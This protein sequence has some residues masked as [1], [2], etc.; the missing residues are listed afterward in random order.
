[1]KRFLIGIL[2]LS[3]FSCNDDLLDIPPKDRISDVA[4]WSDEALIKAY[5]NALYNSILH[6]FNIHMQSKATDEAYCAINWDIG[7]IPLGNLRPDNV[8]SVADTHWTGGGSLYNWNTAYQDIRKINLFLDKMKDEKIVVTDKTRLIAEAKFLRAY[9]YFLLIERFGGVPIVEQHYDLGAEVTF[10]RSSVEEC[11][12]FIEKNL[13]EAMPDLPKK[14]ESTDSNFG[15][16]TQDAGQ[17]LLSRVYLYVC[18]IS[19]V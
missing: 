9:I 14:Y 12:A 19:S 10:D 3:F 11:I 16:A 4:V 15:R 18:S 17:A 6:G 2:L 8:T 13:S 1:M 7:N 5:H